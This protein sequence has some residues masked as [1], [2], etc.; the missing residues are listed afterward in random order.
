MHL[1][2]LLLFSI[3]TVLPAAL[4]Q[5]ATGSGSFAQTI[6]SADT[7]NATI[8]PFAQN[9]YWS[10]SMGDCLERLNNTGWNGAACVPAVPSNPPSDYAPAQQGGFGPGDSLGPP[11]GFYKGNHGYAK[12]GLDGL[13]CFNLCAQCLEL[14]IDKERAVTTSCDVQYANGV[15]CWM[16]FNYVG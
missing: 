16:G 15:K 8:V 5:G 1:K 4:A 2:S 12:E 11:F 10:L 14:G 9:Y 13:D 6:C 3:T 7:S